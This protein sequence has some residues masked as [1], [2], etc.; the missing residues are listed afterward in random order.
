MRWVHRSCSRPVPAVRQPAHALGQIPADPGK[1]RLLGDVT[2]P[3]RQHRQHRLQPSRADRQRNQCQSSIERNSRCLRQPFLV[4]DSSGDRRQPPRRSEPSGHRS[5]GDCGHGLRRTSSVPVTVRRCLTCQMRDNGGRMP[6]PGSTRVIVS[7]SFGAISTVATGAL[8]E[9]VYAPSVGW[10]VAAVVFLGWTWLA[11]AG[12]DSATTE[13]HATLEDP[14]KHAR[15]AIVLGASL[16]SLVG[17][18]L[19]LFETTG[20]DEVLAAALGVGSIALSWIVVHTIYALRYAWLY[21]DPDEG[22]TAGTV[23]GIDFGTSGAP[24]YSDF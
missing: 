13:V 20:A 18:A 1:H 21:Y 16:G 15:H 9:W 19:L 10:D 4:S 23:G 22:G 5:A 2:E 24:R 17:V 3:S 11:L 7:A 14:T 8:G 12:M 6:G